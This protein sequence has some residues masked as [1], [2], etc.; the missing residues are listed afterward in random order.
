MKKFDLEEQWGLYLER[1]KLQE[2]NMHPIQVVETKRSFVAGMSQ[3]FD[4]L[5]MGGSLETETEEPTDEQISENL[6]GI[7]KSLTQFWEDEMKITSTVMDEM[8]KKASMKVVPKED[9]N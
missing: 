2:Q 6:D 9:M 3:M 1:V 8:V 5:A 7:L 4:I